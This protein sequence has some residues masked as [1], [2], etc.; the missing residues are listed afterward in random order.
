[1][2]A[3]EIDEKK[4]FM[5][6]EELRE[7]FPDEEILVVLYDRV[8]TST[9]EKDKNM[10]TR[11]AVFRAECERHGLIAVAYFCE[12]ANGE[13]DQFSER[14]VFREAAM[15]ALEN[16][17]ILVFPCVNRLV[18]TAGEYGSPL[19]YDDILP[20]KALFQNI[21]I[22]RKHL[23][24]L[25]PP[26][27]PNNKAEGI[28]KKWG[29]I[30]KENKGGRPKKTVPVKKKEIREEYLPIAREMKERGYTIDEIVEKLKSEYGVE[31]PRSTVGGWVK[32]IKK[33][34]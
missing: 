31:L 16:D 2:S 15:F 3:T 18:R 5:S 11:E 4:F 17:A 25:I 34:S 8:S 32:S 30:G 26:G 33:I 27:T 24:S 19:T 6:V 20:L 9:Q 1:M 7:K 14:E 28:L 21:G 10:E 29:Q 23:A 13:S 12:A 22:K